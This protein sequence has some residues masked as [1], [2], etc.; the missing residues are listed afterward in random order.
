[1]VNYKF[2]QYIQNAYD[3]RAIHHDENRWERPDIYDPSR[4][5]DDPLS[6]AEAMT[7]SDAEARDHFTYGAGRRS[8]PG[9][10]IAQNSLFINMAR[11][12]WAF[13]ITKARDDNGKVIEPTTST[14]PGFLAVPERFPCRFE[15]R[16][17]KRAE[18]VE[19]V[20][21][22]AEKEGLKWTR[23]RKTM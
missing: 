8:C 15:A 20:W 5:L 6:T 9:V 14:E 7:A 17:P 4:Y 12:L 13:N 19:R 10:H 11:V 1:V 22:E 16:S 2:K 21:A 18:I 23:L 3:I